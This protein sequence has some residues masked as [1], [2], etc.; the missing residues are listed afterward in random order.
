LE[1]PLLLKLMFYGSSDLLMVRL[2]ISEWLRMKTGRR[3]ILA[4]LCTWALVD[5][6]LSASPSGPAPPPLVRSVLFVAS[7]FVS[8][9]FILCAWSLWQ[10]I[11]S[12]FK[13]RTDGQRA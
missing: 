12:K 2:A 8:G 11:E 4:G 9:L 1:F 3:L 5:A 7:L 13:R 10:W 6:L